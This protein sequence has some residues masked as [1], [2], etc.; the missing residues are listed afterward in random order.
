MSNDSLTVYRDLG[1]NPVINAM[2]FMTVLGG[3]PAPH[4]GF[5]RR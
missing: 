2:G 4:R 5:K 1:V 3:F